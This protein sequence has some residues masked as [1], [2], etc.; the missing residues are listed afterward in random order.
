MSAGRVNTSHAIKFPLINKINNTKCR[1][2]LKTHNPKRTQRP[3]TLSALQISA[4][5]ATL[6]RLIQSCRSHLEL[7]SVYQQAGSKRL[8]AQS[9]L[10]AM[11]TKTTTT[12]TTIKQK[13]M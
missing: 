4:V 10:V 12:G 6:V 13:Q 1:R 9:M 5:N 2:S 11:S 8:T 3:F 7:T